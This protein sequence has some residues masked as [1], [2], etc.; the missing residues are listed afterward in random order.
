MSFVKRVAGFLLAGAV[1]MLLA[2][3][4]AAAHKLEGLTVHDAWA[5]ERPAGIKVGGVFLTVHNGSAEADTLISGASPI[6]E[7]VEIHNVA[8][9][10]GV[11]KMFEVEGIEIPAGSTVE[12]KPGGY[13]IM[14]MGLKEPL[15]KGK[16]FPLTLEFAHSGK[17]EVTVEVKDAGAMGGDDGCGGHGD[18]HDHG[19]GDK[20][21]DGHKHEQQ[22]KH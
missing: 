13:H 1:A 12:L 17:I 21:G 9:K 11:M 15:E 10:D 5:R 2:A 18:S 22:H 16:T 7:R 3:G 4:P 20:A 14:L 8:E 19:H 6:A